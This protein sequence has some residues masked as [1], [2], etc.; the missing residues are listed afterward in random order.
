MESNILFINCLIDIQIKRVVIVD[1][2]S[3]T[4]VLHVPAKSRYKIKYANYEYSTT[5]N[6]ENT[7][8][9]KVIVQRDKWTD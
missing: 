2:K 6:S 3:E 1:N 7:V 8:Q 5:N 9:G 4:M